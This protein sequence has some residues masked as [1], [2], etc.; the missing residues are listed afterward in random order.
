VKVSNRTELGEQVHPDQQRAAED[1]EPQ[2]GQDDT[3]EHARRIRAESPR[4]FLDGGIEPAQCRGDRQIHEREVGQCGDQ[5]ARP[6][7]VQGG[8]HT[9]PGVAVDESRNGKRRNEQRTPE[10]TARQ[11][12]PL[13]QPGQPDADDHTQWHRDDHQQDGVDQQL[14]DPG[15]DHE[16]IGA[17]PADRH[18]APHHIAERNACGGNQDRDRSR[19]ERAGTRG[20]A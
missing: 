2:L 12:C 3:E 14:A 6:Q 9:D 15:P 11:I 5:H 4:G 19:D 16:L 8:N 17:C 10:G 13:D 1:R 18:R 7:P 20:L